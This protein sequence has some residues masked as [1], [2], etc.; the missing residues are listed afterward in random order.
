[1]W[2]S[3][4]G[5]LTLTHLLCLLLILWWMVTSWS[6]YDQKI[7]SCMVAHLGKTL[8]KNSRPCDLFKQ[9]VAAAAFDHETL[10]TTLFNS[11]Y[12]CFNVW[13]SL[14][15]KET[16]LAA[17]FIINQITFTGVHTF[18]NV[19]MSIM[20]RKMDKLLFFFLS[21][22]ANRAGL[23]QIVAG[24]KTLLSENWIVQWRL[25]AAFS[26]GTSDH[27]T[28]RP[29]EST[30]AL[31][32]GRLIFNERMCSA[33]AGATWASEWDG[34][35]AQTWGRR[36]NPKPFPSDEFIKQGSTRVPMYF[37]KQA[38]GRPARTSAPPSTSS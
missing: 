21:V 37:W 13:I 15:F 16:P 31:G 10:S 12:F 23:L 6:C 38:S 2:V 27:Q 35:G 36:T 11:G 7:M 32:T 20:L 26:A 5:W 19:F 34:N 17:F 1:M 33:S 24:E 25:A 18:V 22:P 4:T 3:F 30:R 9:Q 14:L 28:A 29:A 8:K